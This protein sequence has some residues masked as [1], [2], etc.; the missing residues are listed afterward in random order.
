LSSAGRVQKRLPL[1]LADLDILEDNTRCLPL[2]AREHRNNRRPAVRSVRGSR[3]RL[4]ASF[5]VRGP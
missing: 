2:I 3:G 5:G 1:M 4:P